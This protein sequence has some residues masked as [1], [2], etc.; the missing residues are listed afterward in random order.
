MRTRQRGVTLMGLIVGA[1]ILIF[2]ALLGMKLLPSYI[3][4]FA[5]K[6]A[7]AGINAQTQGRGASVG[8][9]RR[10]FENRSAVDDINS[11]KS[12]D[13]EISKDGNNYLVVA[14]YRKEIPLFANLGIFIDFRASTKD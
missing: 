12:S 8:E 1:V 9:I 13:L 4:F 7:L 10:M 14:S 5:V 11:V 6:K 3:E 2:V